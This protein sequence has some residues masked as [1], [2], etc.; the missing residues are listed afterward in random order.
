MPPPVGAQE[1]VSSPPC[2]QEEGEGEAA[3]PAGADG[4]PAGAAHE[5]AGAPTL[6]Q[7]YQL[8]LTQV[9]KI[10]VNILHRGICI[11]YLS[12]RNTE[13]LRSREIEQCCFC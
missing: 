2:S 11:S 7:L 8:P 13:N 12:K 6:V 5:Q 10:V 4:P 3:P 1:E 9:C